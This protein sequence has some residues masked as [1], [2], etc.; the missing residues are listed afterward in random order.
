MF[1]AMIQ[2]SVV[3]TPVT[4]AAANNSSDT[5]EPSEAEIEEV[6]NMLEFMYTEAATT[7]SEGYIID[8]NFDL[9]SNEY[10]DSEELRKVEVMSEDLTSN[11]ILPGR[12]TLQQSFGDCMANSFYQMFGV[13][14]AGG[15]FA[16]VKTLLAGASWKAAAKVILSVVKASYAPYLVA[17]WLAVTVGLCL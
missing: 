17:G 6:A 2:L 1:F 12:I 14:V 7:D 15:V 16:S 3:F 9:I 5:Y 13:S 8:L 11:A 10:G 4:V